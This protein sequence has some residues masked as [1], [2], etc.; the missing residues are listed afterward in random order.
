MA[1][2]SD[3]S[4]DYGDLLG[5]GGG[6]LRGRLVLVGGIALVLLLVVAATWWEFFRGGSSATAAAPTTTVTRGNILQSVSTSGV[7]SA[8]QTSSLSFQQSGKITAVN[9]TLGQQVHEGDV[10]AEVDATDEQDALRT[11]E[12]NLS[13]AQAKL[14]T[15]LKGSTASQLASADQSLVQAQAA[16]DKAERAFKRCNNHPPRPIS[17]RPTG[18]SVGA[19]RSRAGAASARQAGPGEPGRSHRRTGR[20]R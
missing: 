17:R 13:A 12:A 10:L 15:L 20:A 1:T 8:Q 19:G 3:S 18:S 7:V 6:A 2:T 9:V 4:F 11:A 16:H 5:D 14:T